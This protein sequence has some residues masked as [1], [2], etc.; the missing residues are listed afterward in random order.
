MPQKKPT[1]DTYFVAIK[2]FLED[3]RGNFFITK[4]R[5]GDWDIPGGRLLTNEFATPLHKVAERKLAEELG[6]SLKYSIAKEPVIFM[7]HERNEILPDGSRGKRRI[8][9]LG[10]RAQY[11][12]G[13]ITLGD[14]H[15]KSQWAKPNVFK[16]EK[17]FTGGWLKGVKEYLKLRKK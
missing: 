2:I 10:Y 8:F 7:R 6:K 12:G 17:Y 13:D 11:L 9:A 4:D 5:F 3:S 14:N 16:A 15:V 1:K